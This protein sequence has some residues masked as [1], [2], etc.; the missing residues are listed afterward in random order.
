MSA[1]D[2]LDQWRLHQGEGDLPTEPL[3]APAGVED[4][5]VLLAWRDL[6]GLPPHQASPGQIADAVSRLEPSLQTITAQALERADDYLARDDAARTG[7]VV[8]YRDSRDGKRWERD[9]DGKVYAAL[10]VA[11][12]PQQHPLRRIPTDQLARGFRVI[13]GET[14]GAADDPSPLR[15]Y[16][17]EAAAALTRAWEAE[18]QADLARGIRR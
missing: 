17:V 16:S 14:K 1:K 18:R 4:V 11:G 12:L 6:L 5:A 13:L 9:R 8:R 7:L 3:P 2:W 10:D 15:W